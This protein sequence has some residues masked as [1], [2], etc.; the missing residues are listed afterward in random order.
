MIRNY[1]YKILLIFLFTGCISEYNPHK[2]VGK[3][4]EVIVISKAEVYSEVES[5]LVQTLERTIYTPTTEHIFNIKQITPDEFPKFR[6][7]KNC[8]IL[9]FIGDALIDSVLAPASRKKLL[10]GESYVFGSEGLFVSGQCVLVIAGP[11]LHKLKEVV[12]NN[13]ELIFNYFAEAVRKRIEVAL[14]KDGYQEA[15]SQKL[16]S[17]YGF[18]IKIPKNWVIANEE[19]GFVEFIHHRPD[20]II[21]IYWEASPG[22]ELNKTQAIGIRDKLGREYYDGDYVEKELTNFYWVEFQGI[23]TGKLDGIWQNEEKVMG[24]PFRTYFFW[25]EGRFYVIDFHIFAPGEKKWKW[26]QQLEVICGTF[27]P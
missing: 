4:T 11:T 23:R 12:H 15:L 27:S 13:S 7:R 1:L 5:L 18:S 14:Y 17:E 3:P 19:F 6:Y 16:H 2:A 10:S 20:R 9:G 8:L 21:S 25:K 22:V 24:G 26:L